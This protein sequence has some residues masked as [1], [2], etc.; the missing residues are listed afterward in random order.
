MPCRLL[1]LGVR[2]FQCL[3]AL[4]PSLPAAFFLFYSPHCL[5]LPFCLSAIKLFRMH[6][7]IHLPWLDTR[8]ERLK[9][10]LETLTSNLAHF[11]P[12]YKLL[13]PNF[14]DVER[15]LGFSKPRIDGFKPSF[16]GWEPR[17][18]TIRCYLQ[19]LLV[20]G[21]IVLFIVSW[22]IF[23]LP[24]R[25]S[26]ESRRPEPDTSVFNTTLGVC[27]HVTSLYRKEFC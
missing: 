16:R 7:Y 26:S 14:H 5:F 22:S 17:V 9:L 4:L 3:Q 25:S 8:L 13:G 1:H 10:Y 18:R 21:L 11:E 27:L 12:Q 24:S 23:L 20:F 15:P 6:H 19:K 2:S